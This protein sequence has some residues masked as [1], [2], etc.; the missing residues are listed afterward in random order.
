MTIRLT[1]L[2]KALPYLK[3]QAA[4]EDA[5]NRDPPFAVLP[6]RIS[7]DATA[8]L[9]GLM[10]KKKAGAQEYVETWSSLRVSCL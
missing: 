5:A 10:D 2:V 3:K 8:M 9:E 7:D 6:E 4:I 1:F